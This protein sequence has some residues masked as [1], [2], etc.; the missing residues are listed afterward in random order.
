MSGAEVSGTGEMHGLWKEVGNLRTQLGRQNVLLAE[1]RTLLTER[2]A[3]LQREVDDIQKQR[4]CV[5]HEEKLRTVERLLWTLVTV[6]AG[7]I[8]RAVYAALG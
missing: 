4:Q 3:N 6:T 5:R 7:L 2:Q 8:G 1:I